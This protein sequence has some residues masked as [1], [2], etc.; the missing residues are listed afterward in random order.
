MLR[1]ANWRLSLV[2]NSS[3]SYHNGVQAAVS[4]PVFTDGANPTAYTSV[5]EARAFR[6]SGGL[7]VVTYAQSTAPG[8]AAVYDALEQG[9]SAFCAPV[10]SR[11]M[12]GWTLQHGAGWNDA[13]TIA[14][15]HCPCPPFNA[16]LL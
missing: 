14:G 10:L 6:A 7:A 9:P 8:G 5:D 1:M 13:Y 4:N 11:V 12:Y 16:L 3:M 15:R 2:N